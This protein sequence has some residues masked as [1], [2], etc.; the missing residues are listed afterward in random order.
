[1]LSICLSLAG[2]LTGWLFF[3]R[4]PNCAR[5]AAEP[6]RN[7]SPSDAGPCEAAPVAMIIPARNE[8]A[9][10]P[11]L[12]GSIRQQLIQPAELLVVND[13]STDNTAAV[14]R[15]AGATVI[16]ADPPPA[17]WHGK[18]WACH[19]GV[20]ASTAP[21][22]LF[23]DADTRF[24]PDGFRRI[25]RCPTEPTGAFSVL[26]FHLVPRWQEQLSAVFNVLMAAGVG[27]FTPWHR[28]PDGLFGQMLLIDRESY[29]AAGGHQSVR[30]H[31]LENLHLAA[32]L[33]SRAIPIQCKLGRGAL[34]MR[35]YPGSFAELVN[36]WAKGF[37]S[38]AGAT[39]PLLLALSI[40]WLSGAVI[41]TTGPLRHCSYAALAIYCAYAAQFYILMR[42]VGSFR[43]LTAAL[44]PIPLFFFFAVFGYA[45]IR[46]GRH[47]SWKGRAVC[48][49]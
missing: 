31:V 12:L 26:P 10:L 28:L 30:Q 42:R 35:M 45:I 39:S 8:Q 21:R 46:R 7:P 44:Y 23:L 15:H 27:A 32:H 41:A 20:R 3:G 5:A 22:L 24:E 37:A 19:C 33:R 9:S 17:G 1:M 43:L 49:D 14:A 2:W 4:N 29:L 18:N 36:G 38:G 25:L 40:A 48:V 6:L 11:H 13:N 47:V 34:S 16:N